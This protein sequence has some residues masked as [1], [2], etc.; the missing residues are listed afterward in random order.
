MVT[1]FSFFFSGLF[2]SYAIVASAFVNAIYLLPIWTIGVPI[3]VAVAVDSVMATLFLFVAMAAYQKELISRQLF[4]S[5]GRERESLARQNQTNARYLDWLRQLASFLRHEVRQPIAQINSSI[6]IAQLTSKHDDQLAPYLASAL[7]G[8]QHVWNLVERASQATDAEAFVRRVRPQRTELNHLLA[9]Q[10]ATF[11]GSNSGVHLN[12]RGVNP[13]YV[14]VDPVVITEAVGNLL[15]NA[16]SFANEDS[17]IEVSLV[18]SR[19]KAEIAVINK[20]PVIQDD[21]E[22]LFGPFASTRAGPSSEHQ[23]FGLYLVRLIA[24]HLGGT[25]TL[26]NLDDGSGVRAVIVLPLPT[27]GIA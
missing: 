15:A 24:E 3:A 14:Y 7:L 2:F 23:G 12:F 21:V 18:A 9:E 19:E 6:E 16:A 1:I 20:G 5:E 8:A 27:D 13:L 25:A 26:A 22:R 17:T 10:V 4:V 11:A